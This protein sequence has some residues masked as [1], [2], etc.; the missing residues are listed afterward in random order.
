MAAGQSFGSCGRGINGY[1]GCSCWSSG[2]GATLTSQGTAQQVYNR[3]LAAAATRRDWAAKA[4][5]MAWGVID[6]YL[7]V[8]VAGF[9][10]TTAA[11]R[12]I[13]WRQVVTPVFHDA[14]HIPD[15]VGEALK[16]EAVGH[17]E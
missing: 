5:R 12:E 4:M 15:P 7:N 8:E 17:G 6:W 10:K 9:P 13:A 1:G 16:R 14:H 2:D 11:M 3:T